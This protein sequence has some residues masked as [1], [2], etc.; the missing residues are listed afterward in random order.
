MFLSRLPTYRKLLRR[1]RPT[2][3]MINRCSNFVMY[4]NPCVGRS[5]AG[6][7][8]AAWQQKAAG[9]SSGRFALPTE[10]NE[11]E[12]IAERNNRRFWPRSRCRSGN[13]A[14]A[15]GC[16]FTLFIIGRSRTHLSGDKRLQLPFY[17]YRQPVLRQTGRAAAHAHLPTDHY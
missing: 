12:A 17:G 10:N 14:G 9:H 8:W 6:A 13:S 4:C 16:G 2:A 5:A 3:L 7:S 1:L 15:H 11:K